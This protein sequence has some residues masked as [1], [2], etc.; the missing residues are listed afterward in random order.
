[1]P[2]C[3][4]FVL[5]GVQR[6]RRAEVWQLWNRAARVPETRGVATARVAANVHR[7][8]AALVAIIAFAV[9]AP[10]ACSR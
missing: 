5:V 9:R 4:V 10:S 3:C 7:L 6:R 1:M 8:A 2:I